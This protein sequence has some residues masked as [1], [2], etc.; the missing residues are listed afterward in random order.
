[1]RKLLSTTILVGILAST[2]IAPAFADISAGALPS[3]NNAVNAD[4]TTNNANMNIKINGGQNGVGVL[5]WNTYNVG[6]DASVNYEFSAHNQ[7]ALN[8]VDAAGG[9]SQIYGK[10]TN[11]GCEG[12]N[13]AGTG[14]V[15]LINPNGVL[16][17]DGANIN[18]NSFTVSTMDA[19]YDNNQLTLD[20][21]GK[22]SSTGIVVQKGATIYGDK[23]VAFA[24]DNV[25]IYNGSQ[26]ST[27]VGNN[28]G[29]VAYGKIK[30][31][32]ADGVNFAYYN[33]GAVKE[34]SGVK[35]SADKMTV[36]VNG[37]LTAGN[38]D[39][40]NY[41]TSPDSQI[42]LNGA[43]L[44]A[45]KAE[46][47]NDGNIWLT[48]AN[49]VVLDNSSLTTANGGNIK[50]KGDKKVSIKASK[51][52]GSNDVAM[53][54][55]NG[56]AIVDTSIVTAANDVTLSAGKIA[57]VQLNSIVKGKNLNINAKDSVSFNNANLTAE[58][59]TV[60][61][62]KNV[63]GI[64]NLNNSATSINAGNDVDLTLANVGDRNADLVA[65]AGHDMT[66]STDGDLAVRSLISGNNMTL[67]AKQIISGNHKTSE[68]LRETGDSADRAYIEVGGTFKSN[69]DFVVTDS[70]DFTADKAF[71]KRHHIQYN[72]G[73]EKIL[74]V[75]NRPYVAPVEP[76]QPAVQ[77]DVDSEQAQKLNKL[78]R[79][80]ESYSNVANISDTRTSFVDVFAAA[81][82]IE[83]VDDEDEE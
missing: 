21:N 47:G 49:K 43:A 14:K 38:I 67:N 65:K 69:P 16:F 54:S 71:Q 8:K 2:S 7:T 53:I 45:V 15:I 40:R 5:N 19:N 6:K 12:C 9:L 56:N 41:S 23:N 20:R 74:L 60:D 70:A 39:I 58:N 3:L 66:I 37:K 72:D 26:I 34:I 29:D 57:S 30:I 79:Q 18:L 31:V 48:A 35:G 75:N 77:P 59:I 73:A 33:N 82:Q 36:S 11:S 78:P 83:I 22:T 61:A 4:V 62:V 52:D 1:M 24:S 50:I 25:N 13:Y 46:K 68:V 44:K 27:N 80:P 81:S 32:T 28:V 55:K 42:N 51:L 63:K 64:A 17:G 76:E 10:I